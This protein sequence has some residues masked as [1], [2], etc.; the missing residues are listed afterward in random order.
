MYRPLRSKIGSSEQ[1]QL[2]FEGKLSEENRWVNLA[3]LVPWEEFES[4]YAAQFSPTRGSPAKP[5]RVALGALIIKERLGTSD[6]ETVEQI[7]ENPYLQYF[8]GFSEYTDMAPFEASMLVHFRK[9]ISL[10]FVG[11]VNERIVQQARK[12]AGAKAEP[13][14][15]VPGEGETATGSSGQLIVDATV[16]PAD[17]R[18][19]TDLQLLNEA[20]EHTEA[21]I[22]SL[23]EQVTDELE[24]KP[25]THRQRARGEFLELSKKRR[26]SIK[27][28]RKGIGKQL[29]Y[30]RRNLA[31]IDRLM[32]AGACLSGLSRHQYRTLL[33]VS[34]LFRQQ[35]Q[36]YEQRSHRVD[37][38]IVSIAQPH[39]RPIVRGKAGTAV[40]FGAKLSGSCCDG[41]VFVERLSWDQF[42]EAGDL[43]QQA[44]NYKA[45]CGHYPETLYADRI[46]RTRENRRWCQERGIRL[47]GSPLGRVS[48]A[49]KAELARQAR[50]DEK[51]RNQIEGKFGQ[52]KRRFGL[53]RVM[54]KLASTSATVIGITFLVINLEKLLQQLFFLYCCGLQVLLP[55][56]GRGQTSRNQQ[57]WLSIVG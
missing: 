29:G 37:D 6:E 41:F 12:S 40:E 45:R 10:D 9:R 3:R 38:R 39:I 34:E 55:W 11:R 28:R 33:V 22:D 15:S 27:Q 20:R 17:I 13:E 56:R 36:M 24:K 35:Q 44:E 47:M 54:A 50:A 42:N 48:E 52:G 46:Y 18:Y 1:F 51:V 23:Y 25:R 57:Y 7:R 49:Q 2:P 4:E 26:P 32:A 14:G 5:F 31:H 8:L 43:P 19:P 16:A 53:A 30:V 21:I